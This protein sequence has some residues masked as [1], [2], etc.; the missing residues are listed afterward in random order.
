MKWRRMTVRM[1]QAVKE[2]ADFRRECRQARLRDS[3]SLLEESVC[4]PG[5]GWHEPRRATASSVYW[6][7]M[8]RFGGY[9]EP[10]A[11]FVPCDGWS[12]TMPWSAVVYG[13]V[14]LVGLGLIQQLMKVV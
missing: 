1:R 4:I 11:R 10:R 2:S 12:L 13:V 3:V 8:R 9:Y 6:R 5:D 7:Y 14:F